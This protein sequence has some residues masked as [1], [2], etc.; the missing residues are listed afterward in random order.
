MKYAFLLCLLPFLAHTQDGVEKKLSRFS[1]GI[2]S[3][4]VTTYMNVRDYYWY[5]ELCCHGYDDDD[6]DSA[7]T[8][9]FQSSLNLNYRINRIHQIG[10][11]VQF[12][13]YGESHEAGTSSRSMTNY[14]GIAGSYELTLLA[15]ERASIGLT[16]S[17]SLDI[18]IFQDDRRHFLKGI[19]HAFGLRW[20]F[21]ITRAVDVHLNC[22]IRTALTQ[23]NPI[24]WMNDNHRYGYGV[25]LGV[26]HRI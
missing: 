2:E 21:R 14:I 16:N 23:Y 20:R 11:S 3:G 22:I 18:P 10:S 26:S 1:I 25:L 17:F 19:S 24:A 13:Q 12:S 5:H 7:P 4:I 8:Y 15:S 6:L 9:S